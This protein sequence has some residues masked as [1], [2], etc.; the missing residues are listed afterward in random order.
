MFSPRR[1][2]AVL[3][4]LLAVLVAA[5]SAVAAQAQKGQVT[6][7]LQ[8][9]RVVV[10]KDGAET[11][12][13]AAKARPGDVLEYRLTYENGTGGA[14]GNLQ[15]TLP[16]PQGMAFVPG[17]CAPAGALASADGANY[18]AMPLM[19]EQKQPDGSVKKIPVP[20][21]QY[22]SLRWTVSQLEA[23]GRTTLKARVRILGPTAP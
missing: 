6:S 3:V 16:I 9:Y 15:A 8:A 21:E 1:P 14:I 5:T 22:R 19:R 13:D 20:V 10:G 12:A 2:G 4:M 23:G 18:A 11:F 17:S 7:V